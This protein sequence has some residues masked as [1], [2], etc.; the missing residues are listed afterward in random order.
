M[1]PDQLS[2]FIMVRLSHHSKPDLVPSVYY[3]QPK[4]IKQ[5]YDSQTSG[6]KDR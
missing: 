6:N 4:A 3:L 1:D 5:Y 2:Y